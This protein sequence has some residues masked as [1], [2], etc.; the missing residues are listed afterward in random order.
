MC[1]LNLY[2]TAG[3]SENLRWMSKVSTEAHNLTED[4]ARSFPLRLG[5]DKTRDSSNA[6]DWHYT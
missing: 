3:R 6:K 2:T 5:R 4:L 1:S